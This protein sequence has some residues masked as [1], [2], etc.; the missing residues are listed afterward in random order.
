[1]GDIAVSDLQVLCTY[2]LNDRLGCMQL[3]STAVKRGR[4]FFY[5]CVDHQ[6]LWND[7]T[8][9]EVLWRVPIPPSKG[10]S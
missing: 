8:A 10:G 4:L 9:G 2:P 6:G 1:M 3:A 7:G 5:R